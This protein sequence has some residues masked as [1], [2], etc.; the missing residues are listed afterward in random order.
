M[1][2]ILLSVAIAFGAFSA[3]YAQEPYPCHTDEK[4]KEFVDAL[5]PEERAQYLAEKEA[6]ELFIQE[7]IANNPISTS[8]TVEKSNVILYTIPVVFHIIHQG[9]PENI[10]DEQ[11]LNALQHMNDDY[12]KL[13]ASAFQVV[14]HFQSRVRSEEH[15]S[16]LQS[17]P[18][19]VCRLLLEKKKNKIA[20]NFY[21]YN[22]FKEV[23]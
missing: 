22:I 12:Q 8:N 13:N 2:K 15:T 10:S 16:E 6:N 19:L 18:H 17:R 4:T 20:F 21:L 1:K 5:S 9:G 14:P 7:Y 23:F 11:V 3:T